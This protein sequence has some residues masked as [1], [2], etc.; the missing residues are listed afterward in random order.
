[1]GKKT[2]DL[3]P[4]LSSS[5]RTAAAA[6][7]R[8][9]EFDEE[10][11][12]RLN[13]DVRQAVASGQFRSGLDH[14]E[15]YG[16]AEG[17]PVQGLANQ[18]RDKIIM[19]GMPDLGREPERPPAF[20]LDAIK[21]SHAGGLFVVGWLNDA[22][23]PIDSLDLYFSNWS[24]AFDGN[25][26]A[27][28]R[29]TDAEAALGDGPPHAYGFWGFLFG[30][31]KL[32]GS[33]CS[34]VVRLKSGLEL[35][36]LVTADIVTDE[37]LRRIALGHLAGTQYF[38]NPYFEA[39]A[40]IEPAIGAQIVDF[41][42]MLSRRA[43]SG[44]YVE[45]FG[46]SGRRYAATI[47]VCLYGKPEYMFLQQAEFARLPGIQDYEFIYVSNGPEIAEPLLKEAR[48][49][50]LIYG[51]DMS[52][53][54]LSANA[55]FGAA[56][57]VAAA[58]ASSERVII[59][60][61]DVF[62][63]SADWASAHSALIASRPAAETALFGVPLYYDDGSL[64]HG[65]MY[66][67]SDTAPRFAKGRSGEVSILR[68]EHYGKGAP[69]KTAQFTAARPVPGVT[70]ALISTQKSWFER[71]G[72]FSPDYVFGHYEDADLCL[73][74]LA[75]GRPAWLH[76]LPLWHLEG[77]GS[78]RRPEHE[79]GSAVNRWLFTKNWGELVRRELLGPAPAH[80]ALQPGAKVVEELAEEVAKPPRRARA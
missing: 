66:F 34:V 13:P 61:P 32:P 14:F 78:A 57:N 23:D 37:E 51:I 58:Y 68:V 54:I 45:R 63:H 10:I 49:C 18:P 72:G 2:A 12:L 27:R 50:A 65:G 64:M 8:Y 77:K 15:R 59:M 43:V 3:M 48:L 39:V 26:L 29:R 16:R 47:V 55:G 1:M 25:S 22:L 80:A 19:S 76:D 52:V 31:R 24:I 20:A 4:R 28:L 21:L 9:V 73:K 69:P 79:G 7:P 53:I 11:Y 56:N 60:N 75:A 74:S 36:C 46:R 41:N 62:P 67:C 44:P 42:K 71:L 5:S 35:S 30:A 70:G 33:V 40:A 17:R 38:G 6:A